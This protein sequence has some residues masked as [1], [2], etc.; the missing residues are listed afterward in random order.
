MIISSTRKIEFKNLTKQDVSS[1]IKRDTNLTDKATLIESAIAYGIGSFVP[2]IA[3]ENIVKNFKMAKQ[4][5]GERIIRALTGYDPEFI[6]KNIN[7]SEFR[8]EI[9]NKITDNIEEL[10]KNG[11]IDESYLITEKAIELAAV[12]NYFDEV[13]KITKSIGEKITKKKSVYGEK[14][15]IR[16]YK[17]G[18]RYKNISIRKTI[19]NAIRRGHKKI[20]VNDIKSNEILKKGK[21]NIIYAIDASG[22]MKGEKIEY[23][24]RAGL[25]LVYK[26][27]EEKDKVGLIVFGSD[28]KMFIKP[29]DNLVQ[30][31]K[32]ITRI[33]TSRETNF[34]SMIKKAI[35]I[36]PQKNITKHLIIITD[37]LPTIGKYPE[38]ET[39]R[40]VSIARSNNITISVI[41]INLNEKGENIAENIV[42]IG[43]GRFYV[44]KDIKE[45]DKIVLLDYYSVR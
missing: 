4:I 24:K 19:K 1:I 39:Y 27:I 20:H 35:E 22:S 9:K 14:G 44:V 31:I 6:E 7:I 2:D 26:T 21:I 43:E 3:F 17:K 36:F 41:G 30:L 18:D 5:Y 34:V 10:R 23:A 13:D 33:K 38:K 8:K 15:E 40:A 37:A 45:I 11:Y 12:V 32:E 42:E 25:A 16:N 28:V 29:T